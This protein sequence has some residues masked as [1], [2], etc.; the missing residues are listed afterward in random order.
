MTE[1]RFIGF[2]YRNQLRLIVKMKR[3]ESI[4]NVHSNQAWQDARITVLAKKYRCI[5][6]N[7]MEQYPEAS[8][9]WLHSTK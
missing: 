2:E 4:E 6:S 8:K 1:V 7:L 3:N 5:A 9:D